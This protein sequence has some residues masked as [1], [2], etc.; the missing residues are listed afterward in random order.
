MSSGFRLASNHDFVDSIYDK[1]CIRI[2]GCCPSNLSLLCVPCVNLSSLSM[3][4]EEG[5]EL[6]IHTWYTYMHILT[7]VNEF[8]SEWCP[9]SYLS[10]KNDAHLIYNVDL[11]QTNLHWLNSGNYVEQWFIV[12][13]ILL[14]TICLKLFGLNL[15][16]LHNSSTPDLCM[17]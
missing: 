10:M 11:L 8:F 15:W 12:K 13:E 9:F 3:K 16:L 1:V 6:H 7:Y 5:F 4:D 2:L 17:K 14:G